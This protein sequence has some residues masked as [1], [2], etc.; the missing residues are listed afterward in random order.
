MKRSRSWDQSHKAVDIIQERRRLQRSCRSG[1]HSCG[2][3]CILKARPKMCNNRCTTNSTACGPAAVCTPCP[4]PRYGAAVCILNNR[5]CG[6]RCLKGFRKVGVKCVR[7]PAP[8]PPV[9]P[10]PMP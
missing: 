3:S 2:G 10:P 4:V 5:K 1:Y 6:T 9:P 7:I 8:P